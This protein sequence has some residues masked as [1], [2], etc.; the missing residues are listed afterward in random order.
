M[1]NVFTFLIIVFLSFSSFGQ[2]ANLET[3]KSFW[4]TT[5][6]PLVD[7]DKETIV[8]N[9]NFPVSGSWGYYLELKEDEAEWNEDVF[10]GNLSSIF[11]AEFRSRLKEMNFNYLVHHTDELGKFHFIL[12]VNFAQTKNGTTSDMYYFLYFTQFDEVWKL[13]Q[14]EIAG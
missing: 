7:F 4:E 9:T 12:Q 8:K 10:A 2:K 6:I 14:I 13:Y 1:K 5:I 11:S 3:V